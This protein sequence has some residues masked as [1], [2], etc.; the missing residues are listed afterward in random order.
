M[1]ILH[2]LVMGFGVALT[3]MNLFFGAVGCIFGTFIGAMSGIGAPA[4]IA[5]L[6]SLTFGMDPTGGIIRLAGIYYGSMYGGTIPSVLVNV[7]RESASVT[8]AIEGYQMA[9]KGRAGAALSVA[10]VG[11]FIAGAIGVVGLMVLAEP[12]AGFAL[13][14]G[15]PEH[16]ALFVFAFTSLVGLASESRSKTLVSIALGLLVSRWE[17]TPWPAARGS[18]SGAWI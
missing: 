16:F 3:P 17:T 8:T 14:F 11:S 6:L 1:D 13:R 7:P 15:P 9:L 18:P 10:A 4:G 5:I 12:V 2:K